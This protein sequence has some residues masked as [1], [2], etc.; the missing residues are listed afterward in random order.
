MMVGAAL[1]TQG[2]G[3]ITMPTSRS[4]AWIVKL[5]GEGN[6]R[7][8]QLSASTVNL[9][10]SPSSVNAAQT[11]TL[12]TSSAPETFT[13]QTPSASWLTVTS[14]AGN[15][16][17]SA[18]ASGLKSGRHMA[19]VTINAN[20]Y[21]RAI[22]PVT[23]TV[24]LEPEIRFIEDIIKP[25]N[26]TIAFTAK[27]VVNP[28]EYVTFSMTGAPAGAKLDSMGNFKWTP[29]VPGT[30]DFTINARTSGLPALTAARQVRIIV[31][32]GDTTEVVRIN[33]GGGD[34]M[35]MD[36]RYFQA[37]QYYTGDAGISAPE[38]LE[39]AGTDDDALYSDARRS[40]QFG[41]AIP[42]KN[43]SH[44]V[45]LHFAEVY[46]GT[47]PARPG[48]GSRNFNIL[49]EGL[50]RYSNYDIYK[51]GGGVLKAVQ[52]SFDAIVSDGVLN[53]NFEATV[54]K[55]RLAAIEVVYQGE[56]RI[57]ALAPVAD[58]YVRGGIYS[59]TN[60]GSEPTLDTKSRNRPEL[61]RASY[62]KFSLEGYSQIED[63]KLR[64]YGY[65]YEADKGQGSAGIEAIDNNNWTESGITYANAPTAKRTSLRKFNLSAHP[66]YI[67]LDLTN[68]VKSRLT[69]DKVFTLLLSDIYFTEMHGVFNSK[70]NAS[71][72]PQLVIN[73]ISTPVSGGRL[74]QIEEDIL[75]EQENLEERSS[76]YPNPVTDRMTIHVSHKHSEDVSLHLMGVAG[77][78][79]SIQLHS[80]LVPG[81]KADVNLSQLALE[82]GFYLLKIRSGKHSEVIK[83]LI[84]K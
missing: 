46:W 64:L 25:V 26:Q 9:A 52:T 33:A 53:L 45:T 30:Y 5:R 74:A 34:Y 7:K 54:D 41:Y 47:R 80:K 70:E 38:G 77:T 43:G 40:T 4:D 66:E 12:I 58:A 10:T 78:H 37:D 36:G 13:I 18:D 6:T 2:S 72:P 44:H 82:R 68:F 71:N 50:I 63:A 83:I 31:E 17:F 29:P 49:A 42:V 15:F 75:P 8:I 14:D 69:G 73:T 20:G 1:S 61:N 55:A 35:T 67:E 62:I 57:I 39:I 19:T 51:Q 16:E 28:G 60:F 21:E 23:L 84:T 76:V 32:S 48:S 79:F 65:N 22:V 11:L 56:V 3:D 27:A 81:S 24:R 59:N